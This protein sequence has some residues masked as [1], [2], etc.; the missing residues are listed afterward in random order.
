VGAVVVCTDRLATS[1]A[2]PPIWATDGVR[3][4]TWHEILHKGVTACPPMRKYS[5]SFRKH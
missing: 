3:I 5:V 2:S 4:Q 1:T